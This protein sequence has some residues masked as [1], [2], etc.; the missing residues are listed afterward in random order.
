MDTFGEKRR[1]ALEA[2]FTTDPDS[3]SKPIITSLN[4]ENSWLYSIPIPC[5]EKARGARHYFHIAVDPW[6]VGDLTM[7]SGWFMTI[8]QPCQPAARDGAAVEA[9]AR[10]IDALAASAAG[11]ADTPDDG[12][13]RSP[14]GA[15]ALT[16]ELSDHANEPTLRTFDPSIPV[17]ACDANTHALV[18]GWGHFNTIV[19]TPEVNSPDGLDG[20]GGGWPRL[21]TSPPGALPSWLSVVRLAGAWICSGS[22]VAW[23]TSAAQGDAPRRDSILNFPHGF[24]PREPAAEALARAASGP[25]GSGGVSVAAMLHPLKENY[26][27]WMQHTEG[28]EAGL[29]LERALRPRVWVRAHDGALHYSGLF[30]RATMLRDRV[31]SLE[32]GLEA[33]AAREGRPGRRPNFADVG[34]GE[35]LVVT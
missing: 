18:K 15:I 13:E 3:I 17:V 29:A 1:A 12:Q 2:H 8:P 22:M 4:G 34:N 19:T 20:G 26:Q 27:L 33:E 31:R 23:R 16:L 11:D 28:V 30:P 5:D 32:S 14:L 7:I 25:G 24:G 35:A 6:L 9:M 10:E 21:E